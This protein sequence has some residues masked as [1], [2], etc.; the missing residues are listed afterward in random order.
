MLSAQDDIVTNG[1]TIM[2]CIGV[3]PSAVR[4]TTINRYVLVGSLL[5]EGDMVAS[6]RPIVE[7]YWNEPG[8]SPAAISV[9][10]SS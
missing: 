9:L 2:G 7:R 6:G 10:R 4:L 3:T 5:P 8:E 1:R